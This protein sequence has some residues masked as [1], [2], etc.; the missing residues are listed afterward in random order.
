ERMRVEGLSRI[1]VVGNN[2]K[3]EGYVTADDVVAARKQDVRDL[4]G[5]LKTDIQKVQKTTPINEIVN[6]I[7]NSP[8]PIAVV[9][10]QKLVGI[11]VRGAVLAGLS[12]EGGVNGD[13]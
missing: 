6:M 13:A 12:N 5:I 11:L 3:L 8:I 4:K 7:H 2:R 10:E 9:E 1:L